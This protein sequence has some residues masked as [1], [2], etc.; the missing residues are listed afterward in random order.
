MQ[1]LGRV[2]GNMGKI[3]WNDYQMSVNGCLMVNMDSM[4]QIPCHHV[5]SLPLIKCS[6]SFL[7]HLCRFSLK[8][9]MFIKQHFFTKW[10]TEEVLAPIYTVEGMKTGRVDLPGRKLTGSADVPMI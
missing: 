1:N 10:V 3:K 4:N 9:P 5:S 7:I 8:H 6:I 2:D